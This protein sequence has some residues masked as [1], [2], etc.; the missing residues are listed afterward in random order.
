MS[1]SQADGRIKE[2]PQKLRSRSDHE[3]NSK[4]KGPGEIVFSVG[5]IER[6]TG[7]HT[8]VGPGRWLPK[9]AIDEGNRRVFPG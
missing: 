2:D 7:E 8:R 1:F 4:R 3:S 6:C 5:E 9:Q